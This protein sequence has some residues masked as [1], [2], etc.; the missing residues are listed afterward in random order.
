MYM[1]GRADVLVQVVAQAAG[2]AGE[3]PVDLLR[4]LLAV[5]P[6]LLLLVLLVRPSKPRAG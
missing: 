6:I 1:R 2:Q 4:W 5:S 3:L